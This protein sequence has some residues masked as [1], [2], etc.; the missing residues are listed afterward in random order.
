MSNRSNWG[1]RFSL[2][3]T[4][5]SDEDPTDKVNLAPSPGSTA[6]FTP[7]TFFFNTFRS[8]DVQ[9]RRGATQRALKAIAMKQQ[10]K[11]Q[12][13]QQQQGMQV[14]KQR[15]QQQQ[16]K[17]DDVASDD[18]SD[19]DRIDDSDDDSDG[20]PAANKAAKVNYS[21]NRE[22]LTESVV[23]YG[24][25]LVAKGDMI[26]NVQLPLSQQGT[27]RL[28]TQNMTL[29][30]TSAVLGVLRKHLGWDEQRFWKAERMLKKGEL[31][32]VFSCLGP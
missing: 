12:Q 32:L 2:D 31:P 21:Q 19:D 30:Q 16:Q 26:L 14:P 8:A 23:K 10:Q 24:K 27:M 5:S 9:P 7:P 22:R 11:Q 20:S 28:F 3:E 18:H 17:H 6:D 15:Q 4:S 25:R 13:H 1:F 29:E